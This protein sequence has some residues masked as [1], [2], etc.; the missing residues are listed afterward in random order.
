MRE[1]SAKIA[2][3]YKPKFAEILNK[4]QN[5]RLQQIQ[6]QVA[7]LRDESLLKALNVSAEQTEKLKKIDTEAEAKIEA[8]PRPQQ[9]GG[10]EGFQERQ[11]KMREIN[12]EAN[13]A[14]LEVL[15]AEQKEQLT[16][17][18]GKEFDVAQLRGGFGRGG[19]AGGGR[20]GGA[21]AR[22]E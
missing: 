6:W 7:G 10:A 19:N 12:D 5:E 8:L 18:K 2:E 16:K 4:E 22:P 1:K 14:R 17:L 11:T 13:K 21:G 3:E 9:G 20:P 15:T